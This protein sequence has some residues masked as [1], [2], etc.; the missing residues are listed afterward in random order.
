[1]VSQE[2]A[3]SRPQAPWSDDSGGPGWR[4]V[5][6]LILTI[7]LHLGVFYV[8]PERLMPVSEPQP[9]ADDPVEYPISLVEPEPEPQRYVEANPE[10][11][12]NEPDPTDQY[13]A[14][15]QQ[16]AD[17]SPLSDPENLPQVDGES[18]TR[19][20][21]QGMLEPSPPVEPG[22]Y[23]PDAPPGEGPGD[24]GGEPG[25]PSEDAQPAQPQPLP[26]PDFIE[27]ESVSEEGPGSRPEPPGEAPEVVETPAP[28]APVD[29][30]RPPTERASDAPT[31][32]A[33]GGTP[34]RQAKP[35]PRPR[36]DP[37]LTTGMLMRS[38]SSAR[39]RG[40]IAIDATF[41]EFGE[42]EQQFYAAVQTGWYQEIEFFQPIDTAAQV[43]VRF[44]LHADGR[45]SDVE[46]VQSNASEIATIICENAISKRSPFRPWTREMVR[47]FGQERTITVRFN[48]L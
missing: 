34:D 4:I 32:T 1:M 37:E 29:V 12:E 26:P 39:R 47:V 45:V 13:A 41:S 24:A 21:I 9:A 3:D 27:Q 42:Y 7:L 8:M 36:L 44:T 10:V 20:I 23:A 28:D 46:A 33:G 30:Y 6:A 22:V 43:R 16:A 15:S 19:K 17:D 48:Y 18:D 14:R 31:E 40:Q 38:E 11:P 25:N 35:R 2:T 5:V